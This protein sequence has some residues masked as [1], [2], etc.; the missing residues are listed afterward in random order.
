MMHLTTHIR[1]TGLAAAMAVATALAVVPPSSAG[2]SEIRYVVNNV[3]VT[4][5]D[6]QRR[7]ALLRLFR[8]G[9]DAKK[10]AEDMVEHALKSAE[11]QRLRINIP[12]MAVDESYAR[13]ASSNK[14]KPSQLDQILSQAGV[15]KE[16]MKEFIRVQMGWSQ[17]LG[18]RFRATGMMTEQQ[19][20]QKVFELGGKKPSATEYM[21]QKVTFVVPAKERGA[22][23]GKRKREA[24][25]MRQRFKSC[26]STRQFV[27]GLVDVVVQDIPRVLEPELPPDWAPQIKDAKPG[28]AT[29]TRETP[30]GVEFIGICSAREV[31]DDRAAQMILQSGGDMDKQADELSKKYLAELRKVARIQQR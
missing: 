10:A 6:I 15:G 19:M 20:V 11:M 1:A 7:S 30:A 17:A 18:A 31:S 29:A 21:L 3:A 4:S 25:A 26:E 23:L 16:H 9:G 5:Y 14:L 27:K 28:T 8:Q 2:A 13:F 22:I 12:P 24:E